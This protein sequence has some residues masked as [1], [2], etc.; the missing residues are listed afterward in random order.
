MTKEEFFKLVPENISLNEWFYEECQSYE[1]IPYKYEYKEE[2]V[3]YFPRD[4]GI[5]Q[6]YTESYEFIL[7]RMGIPDYMLIKKLD[8]AN[9]SNVIKNSHIF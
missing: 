2:G 6:I 3:R 1:D 5:G 9:K 7:K 8:I 4:G